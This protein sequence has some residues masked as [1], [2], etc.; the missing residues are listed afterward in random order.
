MMTQ[1]IWDVAPKTINQ[2]CSLHSALL[3]LW[4]SQYAQTLSW[5]KLWY[6][7]TTHQSGTWRSDPAPLHPPT[8]QVT[9]VVL[10][11]FVFLFLN[12]LQYT[13][14]Q[15]EEHQC[16]VA[17]GKHIDQWSFLPKIYSLRALYLL[18]PDELEWISPYILCYIT[19]HLLPTYCILYRWAPFKRRDKSL[20]ACTQG[21]DGWKFTLGWSWL[22]LAV[23]IARRPNKGLAGRLRITVFSQSGL[24]LT[25][26]NKQA[27]HTSPAKSYVV[28]SGSSD[29]I[30][31]GC[32]LA[33]N[34]L[35]QNLYVWDSGTK[36]WTSDWAVIWQHQRKR[37]GLHQWSKIGQTR[38]MR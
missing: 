14:P 1:P 31:L 22:G 19:L 37:L 18:T 36:I 9:G 25:R 17:F 4:L 12:I 20:G 15:G 2:S 24:F 32:A 27:K 33:V 38:P 21:M 3:A 6:S 16:G 34:T 11:N 26:E 8:T 35:F 7:P 28:Y 30:R 13:L 23:G 10:S 29:S 5:V